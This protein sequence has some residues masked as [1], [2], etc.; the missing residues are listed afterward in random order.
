MSQADLVDD[1]FELRVQVVLSLEDY[2]NQGLLI[3]PGGDE[4]T[5]NEEDFG[6]QKKQ[7]QKMLR[8]S[9]SGDAVFLRL[10][11]LYL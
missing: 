1:A 10:A 2:V 3:W 7:K 4:T 5:R 11:S 9:T 6:T 8:P